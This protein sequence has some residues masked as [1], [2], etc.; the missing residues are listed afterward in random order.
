MEPAIECMRRAVESDPS[1]PKLKFFLGLCLDY[2]GQSAAANSYFNLLRGVVAAQSRLDAWQYIKSSN[3][4]LPP[5]IGTT[6]QGFKIAFDASS[7][8][9]LVLE[10]GVRFGESIRLI[11]SLTEGEV[12]GFD[13][14]EGLPDA[15]HD[16]PKGSY[17]TG[18]VIPDVPENVITHKGW[19]DDTL[20]DFVA[21]HPQTIRFMHVDCDMY[22]STKTIFNVLSNRIVPGT[23]IAFDEYIGND[24]WREDEVVRIK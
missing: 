11:A 20:P 7:K 24:H 22:S 18:G 15:W 8:D 5:M 16:E 13:S 10:F 2:S 17:G 14:F 4:R 23:V 19:F 21:N 3:D 9:G 1:D 12:H 6:I